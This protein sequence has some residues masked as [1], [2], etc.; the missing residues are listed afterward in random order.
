MAR[1]KAVTVRARVDGAHERS[2]LL[3]L[4]MRF[5]RGRSLLL[6]SSLS[7]IMIPLITN[8]LRAEGSSVLR[9]RLI[10]ASKLGAPIRR[11]SLRLPSQLLHLRGGG[12]KSEDIPARRGKFDFLASCKLSGSAKVEGGEKVKDALYQLTTQIFSSKTEK[13]PDYYEVR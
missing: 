4:L 3:K 12:S 7:K 11:M 13:L 2:S 6:S 8:A 10:G 9:A 1:K 5:S